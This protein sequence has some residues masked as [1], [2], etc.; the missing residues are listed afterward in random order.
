ML[1]TGYAGERRAEKPAVAGEAARPTLG[2]RTK[3]AG[4]AGRGWEDS[5]L[6]EGAGAVL[7][8]EITWAEWREHCPPARQSSSGA[9]CG[10]SPSGAR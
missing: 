7:S 8:G 5:R 1:D 4:S 3:C 9:F 6:T 10:L 2:W